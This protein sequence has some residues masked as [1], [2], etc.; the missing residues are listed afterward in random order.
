MADPFLLK[1]TPLWIS[2]AM[3]MT[4][5]SIEFLTGNQLGVTGKYQSMLQTG[6]TLSSGEARSG[7]MQFGQ[8]EFGRLPF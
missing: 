5:L 6:H 2:V 1:P 3:V 4:G 8:K 7:S